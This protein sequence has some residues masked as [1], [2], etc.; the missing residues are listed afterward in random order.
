MLYREGGGLEGQ[1]SEVRVKLVL[2]VSQTTAGSRRSKNMPGSEVRAGSRSLTILKAQK[3]AATPRTERRVGGAKTRPAAN[4]R[5]RDKDERVLAPL[6]SERERAS[7][8]ARE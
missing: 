3:N 8:R 5:G 2:E 7:E 1:R 4:L 6:P